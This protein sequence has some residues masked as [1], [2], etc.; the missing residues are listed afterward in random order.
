MRSMLSAVAVTVLLA[1]PLVAQ[2]KPPKLDVP[3]TVTFEPDIEYSNVGGESLKLDLA[4][5]KEGN[6]PL[7][8]VVC[9]HG[10]GFRAGNRYGYRPL[11]VTLAEQGYAAVTIEY[12]LA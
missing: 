2:P 3:A 7:P 12:R 9:I 4:R 6:G 10:G 5:P 8:V 1:T 11:C